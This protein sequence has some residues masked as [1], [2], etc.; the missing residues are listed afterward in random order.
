MF[1]FICARMVSSKA[2]GYMMARA[3][4]AFVSIYARV[5]LC[6]VGCVCLHFPLLCACT[7]LWPPLCLPS[8][9]FFVFLA[10]CSSV[11]VPPD[12]LRSVFR[13]LSSCSLFPIA[14]LWPGYVCVEAT[15]SLK[16]REGYGVLLISSLS[17]TRLLRPCPLLLVLVCVFA[18]YCCSGW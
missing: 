11:T 4:R 6:G 12:P 3:L 16:I 8:S 13:G 14:R 7:T 2:A 1:V 15:T 5:S 17:L 10:F 18:P 9:A